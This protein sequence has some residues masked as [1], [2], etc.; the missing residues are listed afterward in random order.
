MSSILYN[1]IIFPISQLLEVFYQFIYEATSKEAYAIIGLSFVVTLCTLPLYIVAEKWQ[2]TERKTLKKLKPGIDRIKETF[3]GDEQYMILNTFYRQN[4]YSPIMALRSSFSLLIQIPF[5]LAAYHFLSEFGDLKGVSFLFIKDL[6]APDETFHF[7]SFAINVL[8]IAMTIINCM[9]GFLYSKGHAFKEKLQIY[10]FAIIFLIILY[11]SPSGL[12]V[13]WT[14]NN[15]LSL[16]KNIFYKLKNPK[17]DLYFILCIFS[18]CCIIAPFSILQSQ[19]E[20]FKKVI[21][22]FG[23]ILPII[24]FAII[25]STK[26][27]D[28]HFKLLDENNTLRFKIFLTSAIALTILAGLAIPSTI[29]ESEPNN[30]FY[31]DSYKSPFVFLRTSFFQSAGVFLLWSGAIYGLFSKRIKKLLTMLFS[32]FAFASLINTFAFGGNYGP[33]EAWLEF[34]QPQDFT[35]IISTFFI[36]SIV[37]LTL[38]A[39]VFFFTEHFSHILHSMLLILIISLT[40]ISVKNTIAINKAFSKAPEPSYGN[41][42]E[43]IFHLSKTNPN[44]IVIMQDRCFSPFI[45]HV[46]EELPDVK[47]SF[48]GF[49]YYPNT[50]SMGKLTMIGTPGIFGGYDYTPYRI[51]QRATEEPEKTLQDKHN[52]ALLTL[53]L[54]FTKNGFRAEVANLP[55]ENYL[56]QPESNMYFDN[57]NLLR[58]GIELESKEELNS[59]S[60]IVKYKNHESI[61]HNKVLATYTNYWYAQHG[62]EKEPFISSQIFRNFIWFSLFKMVSPAL[63][64][65]V[66]H[67]DYWTVYNKWDNSAKFVDNYS[68]IDYLPELTEIDEGKGTLIVLD[69]E[70]THEPTLLQAPEYDFR[71]PKDITNLGNSFLKE[72]REFSTM[73]GIFSRYKDFFDYLKENNIYDNTRIIIVSDHG[74]G[75]DL[76]GEAQETIQN[77]KGTSTPFPKCLFVATLMVKDF[78]SHGQIKSDYTYMTNADTPYL[79]VENLLQ[80]E[81]HPFTNKPL[82]VNNK[83]AYSVLNTSKA[84][85]TRIR[86]EKTFNVKDTEW[87]TVKDNIFIDENWSMLNKE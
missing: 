86:K 30:Y 37:M 39:I 23:I 21:L 67:R 87:Y 68:V 3:K 69:N 26:F 61:R 13:Y 48:D 8:P 78:H 60:Y 65:V 11:P 6:G 34:M 49:T 51:N 2:E 59:I 71:K 38:I 10:I 46:F 15:I 83:N 56:E 9:S 53:P 1:L 55:Y 79:C 17:K 41:D 70:A 44:V 32:F 45:P 40:A 72:N 27:L 66:Y 5:F 63:R 52:E 35:I 47:K 54:I 36:N 77:L 22:A 12:V 42:L 57:P 18:L 75:N 19:K 58:H 29:I 33:V 20:S 25:R 73:C 28:N 16:V 64:G 62:M 24:P 76:Q 7:G 82:F 31:V 84:Q 4:H 14:M 81:K 50:I 43:P 74:M 80:D 85:S